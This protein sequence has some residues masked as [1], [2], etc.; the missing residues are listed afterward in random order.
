MHPG[1]ELAG[2]QGPLVESERPGQ[3]AQRVHRAG[4]AG[5]HADQP[6]AGD[7]DREHLALVGQLGR[8]IGPAE[9]VPD[10]EQAEVAVATVGVE[11]RR[12]AAGRA[13]AK[14]RSK[15]SSAAP[16]ARRRRWRSSAR[17]AR[18]VITW[19]EQWAPSGF[20]QSSAGEHGA[21]EATFGLVRSQPPDMGAA[22]RRAADVAVP[23]MTG[24]LLDQVDLCGGV[25]AERRRDDLDATRRHRGDGEADQRQD[26]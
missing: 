17:P 13:A 19:S 8:S 18:A 21:H 4:H 7:H 16:A 22:R 20:G 9:G 26:R 6:G 12:R 14:T 3:D 10:L 2:M 24:D 25:G 15:D 11:R 23:V 1:D 5:A